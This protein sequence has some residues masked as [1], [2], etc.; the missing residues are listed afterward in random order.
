MAARGKL[1]RIYIDISVV[2]GCLDEEFR[3]A[4]IRLIERGR[5]GD[6]LLV[7]SDTTL[8]ELAGAPPQVRRVIEDLPKECIEFI[9]QDEE[10]EA[11]AEEYIRL[12]VV[13]RR[14]LADAQHIAVATIAKADVLVSWNFK[15]IVNLDRIRG[16]N[17]VNLLLGYP[18]LEIRSPP[19]I[20]RD[21]YEDI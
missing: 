16:F 2:G 10:S 9:Q 15:H 11:L 20:W 4:S 6:V 5:T 8:A 21:D 17:A 13:P 19:E 12:E 18:M 7:I 14:M 3:N 1:S